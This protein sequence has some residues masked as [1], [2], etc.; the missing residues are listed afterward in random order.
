MEK[1][2]KILV[3]M[4]VFGLVL[5]S[6]VAHAQPSVIV[7]TNPL[8][9][10]FGLFNA[11]VELPVVGE[12]WDYLDP[13]F[14]VAYASLSY[15]NWDIKAYGLSAGL[16][17]FFSGRPKGFYLGT[18]VGWVHV[19][20]DYND[21]YYTGSGSANAFSI[22]GVGGYRWLISDRVVVGVELGAVYIAGG[23]VKAECKDRWGNYEE[24]STGK[25]NGLL[26]TA[27][28]TIGFAF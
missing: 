9:M 28:I 18:S 10:A 3:F 23:E 21:S 17:K 11:N 19:S 8:A 14:G 27:G 1:L 6:A 16:N 25:F 4:A 24:E 26:P 12:N 20:A 2:R 5:T 22:S 15:D 13:V 7:T